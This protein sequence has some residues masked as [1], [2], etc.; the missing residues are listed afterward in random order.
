VTDYEN[1][2]VYLLDQN[3][4]TD[5]GQYIVREFVSRHNKSGDFLSIAQLWIE[6]EAGVGLVTGQ[7]SDPK[8]MLQISRDGGHSWGAELVARFGKLGAYTACG[9]CGTG[10]AARVTG[11][12][13]SACTDPV[14]TVFVAAWARVAS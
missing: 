12:S 3:A 10:S 1:G 14:K 9:R 4:Y 6:M 8:V 11:C 7:G 13:S 2:K 5:D